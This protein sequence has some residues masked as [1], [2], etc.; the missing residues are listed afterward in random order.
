M[1]QLADLPRAA[2]LGFQAGQGQGS[3]N[4]LGQFIRQF[5]SDVQR[6][7]LVGEQFGGEI[8]KIGITQLLK[9]SL[10]EP[11]TR[12]RALEALSRGE[13]LPGLNMTETKRV[14][15]AFINPFEALLAAQMN[16]GNVPFGNQK[17][18]TETDIEHNMVTFDKTR[19]EVLEEARK[20]G[21]IV[22]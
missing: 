13:P 16:E 6:R 9:S 22:E 14:A 21:Y 3:I 10:R 20:K 1:P 8:S 17:V 15:G 12:E 11:S 4:P 7:R 2:S 5:I 19:E 18:L